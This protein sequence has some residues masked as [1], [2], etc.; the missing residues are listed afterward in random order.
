M[1]RSYPPRGAVWLPTGGRTEHAA[2]ANPAT[3]ATS[4]AGGFCDDNVA[5]LKRVLGL[6]ALHVERHI[7]LRIAGNVM[8]TYLGS[9]AGAQV[10]GGAIKRGSGESIRAVIWVSDL[11][12]FTD[13]T[14]RL[15]GAEV[16]ALL[17]AYFERMVGA[18]IA[19][20][21]E[22][23]KFIGDGV[24][25]IFRAGNGEE[26]EACWRAFAAAQAGLDNVDA[27]GTGDADDPPFDVVPTWATSFCTA[28]VLPSLIAAKER[29]W[30]IDDELVRRAIKYVRR[31][32]L[33][34]GAYSYD[35][36]GGTTRE[37]RS[38]ADTRF[39]DVGYRDRYV[40]LAQPGKV[41]LK[42]LDEPQAVPVRN[43]EAP[44]RSEGRSQR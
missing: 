5:A 31:C 8:D 20:G 17:N 29:G 35:L 2:T 12:G 22:V 7:V 3:A 18:V 27:R 4:Q 23:L 38:D 21:G 19:H 39:G 36:S 40:V 44:R 30:E 42:T 1:T 16:T 25:A 37:V 26:T 43:R 33:P 32:R 41:I 15:S 6:F 24:L 9:V 14:D 10:L 11:R 34:G 28:L 13:L